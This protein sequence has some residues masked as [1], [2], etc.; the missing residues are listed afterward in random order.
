MNLLAAFA[1]ACVVTSLAYYAAATIIAIRFAARAA[2]PPL[3]LPKIAPRVAILKPLHG[4]T[5][6]LPENLSSYL[7]LDYRRVEY[8]FG[9]SGYEDRAVE[10]PVALKAQYPF[11]QLRMVVGEHPGCSNRKVA[12]LI[13]MAER[14][15]RA[16]ILVVADADVSVD[17]GH[18]RRIVGDLCADQVGVVT[19]LYRAKP[20]GGLASRLEALFVNTDF[21][22]LVMVSNLIEPI[23]YGLGATIAIKRSTLEAIGGFRALK[24]MLAD[25]YYLGK[26]ASERGYKIRLSTS[27]VTVRNGERRFVEFWKH[28]IRWAR[29]YRTTRPVSVA[30]ILLH[31]PFW[32][33][34]LLAASQF[35]T[36]ALGLFAGVIAARV[37]MARLF[38]G[39]VLQLPE[40]RKDAWLAPLKDLTM[41]AIWVVSLFGNEVLWG[42]RRLRIQPDGTMRELNS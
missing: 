39:K 26:L 1:A 24:D 19:C 2:S 7:E 11:A 16:E 15:P 42:G 38:I 12:K 17:R 41:T 28:Q 5:A 20:C 6:V 35:S 10:V 32:S 8:L 21:V 27:I 14:V 37:A 18:L 25:D 40:Q 36:P 3:P 29:T 9:V 33:L 31:G 22:P 23:R 30:T 13:A 34:V 4:L